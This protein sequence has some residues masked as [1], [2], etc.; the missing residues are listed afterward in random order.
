MIEIKA[1]AKARAICGRR[2][3]LMGSLPLAVMPLANA[4]SSQILTDFVGRGGMF[5]GKREEGF[6]VLVMTDKSCMKYLVLIV[7][8]S[9]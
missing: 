1:M 5:Q 3:P 4:S 2:R 9:R 8:V 6:G 7:K